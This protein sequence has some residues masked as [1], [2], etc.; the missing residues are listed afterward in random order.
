MGVAVRAE[1]FGLFAACIPQCRRA[2][3]E[4]LPL[5]KRQ[6]LVPDILLHLQWQDH[7]PV[8]GLLFEVKTWHFGTSTYPSTLMRRCSAVLHRAS[9]LPA[10]Y[11]AQ[12]RCVDR[13]YYSTLKGALGPVQRKLCT[14]DAVRGL[15]FGAWGEASPDVHRLLTS[16]AGV[17]TVHHYRS[18]RARDPAGANGALVWMLRRRWGLAAVREN[19]RLLLGR[20]DA[21]GRGAGEAARR[22]VAAASDTAARSRRA[23]CWGVHG[24]RIVIYHV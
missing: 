22:R 18:M 9:A 3:V 16:L 24:P 14:F 11:A 5:R 1:V 17:G 13:E 7:G 21:I 20:L 10:E 12:A 8:R 6:G 2:G 19:A 15:V 4:A 23:A